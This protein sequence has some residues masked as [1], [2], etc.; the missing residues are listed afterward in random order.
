MLYSNV[1]LNIFIK[2]VLHKCYIIILTNIISIRFPLKALSE[3]V[4]L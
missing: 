2:H 3:N 1:L 4:V